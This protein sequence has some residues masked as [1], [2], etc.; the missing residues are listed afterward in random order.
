LKNK[1]KTKQKTHTKGLS[2]LYVYLCTYLYVSNI[3]DNNKVMNLR[4]KK[5]LGGVG[6]SE[7]GE[8]MV[9]IQYW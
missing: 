5:N 9:Y 4:G 7:G 3:N 6:R 2:R 8:E 1:H